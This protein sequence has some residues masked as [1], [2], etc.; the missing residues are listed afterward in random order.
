[1]PIYNKSKSQKRSSQSQ[2]KNGGRR[3]KNTMRKLR[4]GRK[5]RKVIRGGGNIVTYDQLKQK[6]E[7]KGATNAFLQAMSRT[8]NDIDSFITETM[9][10]T[11]NADTIDLSRIR[12][13]I[14]TKP[15]YSSAV[16]AIDEL[17]AE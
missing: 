14:N 11:K 3:R 9:M 17:I 6:L 12:K 1:M 5:S 8:D 2:S 4:R 13:V 10:N 15:L 7:E 16:N